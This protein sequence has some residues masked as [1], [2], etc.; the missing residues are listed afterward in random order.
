MSSSQIVLKNVGKRYNYEWIFRGVDHTFNTNQHTVIRGAN[1]SGKSTLLQSILGNIVITEGDISYHVNGS[2]KNEEQT[3]GLFSLATP[4]LDLIE[5]FTLIELLQF[6]EKMLGFKS[7]NSV[8][9]IVD[10][11]YLTASK[12]KALRYYSSGMK[13]RVKL[14][15]ALLSNTPFVLLDEPTSNLDHKAIEWY[16]ELVHDNKANRIIIVCSNDQK[17]E[18]SFCEQELNLASFK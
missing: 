9:S 16:K 4:Y 1:G 3:L 10:R 13:Q 5:E 7:G 17:D 11:L 18:F 2:V 6:H 14:G 12:N 15:L 8:P